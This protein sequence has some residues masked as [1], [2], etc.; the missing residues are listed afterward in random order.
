MSSSKTQ[1]CPLKIIFPVLYYSFSPPVR[2]GMTR[3]TKIADLGVVFGYSLF[4]TSSGFAI[5]PAT[6]LAAATAGFE[7]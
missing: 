4:T 5:L 7:R 2:L 1:A 6:A 3:D